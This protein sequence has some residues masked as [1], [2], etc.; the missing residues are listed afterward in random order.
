MMIM[1]TSRTTAV[2]FTIAIIS[3]LLVVSSGFVGPVYAAAKKEKQ[4][5]GNNLGVPFSGLPEL[6]DNDMS[7]T[8]KAQGKDAGD[9]GW[10]I[11]DI[12]DDDADK[13][14]VWREICNT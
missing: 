4:R 1:F 12:S 10:V 9:L 14:I 8:K 5:H 3:S 6:S 11:G 7:S 2:L 13:T